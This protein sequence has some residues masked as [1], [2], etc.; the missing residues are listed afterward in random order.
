MN[1]TWDLHSTQAESAFYLL[2]TTAESSSV[3]YTVQTAAFQRDKVNTSHSK[4]P[5]I[6]T[7]REAFMKLQ[8]RR[9]GNTNWVLPCLSF[10]VSSKDRRVVRRFGL[11]TLASVDG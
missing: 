9:E 10:I 8:G 1:K 3:P 2:K 7:V 11:I 5:A 4:P 6:T